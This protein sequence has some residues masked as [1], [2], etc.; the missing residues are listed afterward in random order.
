ML[1]K[2]VLTF[3]SVDEILKWY[4]LDEKSLVKYVHKNKFK[5]LEIKFLVDQIFLVFLRKG[6]TIIEKG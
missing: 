2:V 3:E 4:H 5:K 1:Y 6:K